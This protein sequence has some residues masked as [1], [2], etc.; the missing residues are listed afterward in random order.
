MRKK[1]KA[2]DEGWATLVIEEH[3]E[4]DQSIQVRP[5]SLLGK[6]VLWAVI[7]G[8]GSDILIMILITAIAIGTQSKLLDWLMAGGFGLVNAVTGGPLHNNLIWLFSAIA[9]NG[10]IYSLVVFALETAIMVWRRR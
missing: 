5:R 10:I 3:L 7:I 8:F 9:L 1:S 2:K 6:A 4:A